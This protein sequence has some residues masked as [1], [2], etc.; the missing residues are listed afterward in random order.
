[1]YRGSTDLIY[2]Q[3]ERTK[4]GPEG[5]E[6]EVL[7]AGEGHADG[8]LTH[9]KFN[10]LRVAEINTV[11]WGQEVDRRRALQHEAQAGAL[12]LA[13]CEV[14]L[15]YLRGYYAEIDERCDALEAEARFVQPSCSL[16]IALCR[17]CGGAG[18]SF[19]A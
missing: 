4:Q 5:H 14:R 3:A 16:A 19:G 1:M 9:A 13:S 7:R 2:K 11:W 15:A 12:S 18:R 6:S 10:T 17:Q 8:P